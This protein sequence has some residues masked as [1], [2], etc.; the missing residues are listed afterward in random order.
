M[1]DPDFICKARGGRKGAFKEGDHRCREGVGVETPTRQGGNCDVPAVFGA[2]KRGEG[3]LSEETETD[4]GGDSVEE[5]K[6]ED[7]RGSFQMASEK[8]HL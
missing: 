3:R 7:G 8:A 6:K 2:S 1:W 5:R 4:R